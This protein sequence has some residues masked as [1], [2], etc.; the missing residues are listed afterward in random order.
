MIFSNLKFGFTDWKKSILFGKFGKYSLKQPNLI[1]STNIFL[2]QQLV[3]D[4]KFI[5][6]CVI[7][8]IFM[9]D[10]HNKSRD[11]IS[12]N[13]LFLKKTVRKPFLIFWK[14]GFDTDI[15]Q[16]TSVMNSEQWKKHTLI[17]SFLIHTKL[18]LSTKLKE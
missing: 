13:L 16:Y 8:H 14:M 1:T 12:S 10:M 4:W 3:I 17:Y 11:Q 5:F 9:F 7:A 2:N 18:L 6:R 15:V